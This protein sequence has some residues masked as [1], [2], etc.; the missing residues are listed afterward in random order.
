M[1][2]SNGGTLLP[3]VKAFALLPCMQTVQDRN[4]VVLLLGDRLGTILQI[5]ESPRK[6]THLFSVVQA[7]DRRPDGLQALLDVV[8]EL[9]PGTIHLRFVERMI[10]ERTALPLWPKEER[11]SLF[12][13]L[14]GMPFKDLIEL[15]R[16]VAGAGA[17]ELPAE[18]SY[19]EVFLTL[20]TMN[21]DPNGLPKAILFVEQ[22]ASGR[23]H[24]LSIELRR[25][26]DRQASRLGVIT[27]LQKTRREL[28]APPPG[29]PP[30]SPAYLV[31]MLRRVG[32][33]GDQYQLFNW[34]QLDLS[35]GWH[36][37]RGD[38]F[39]GTIDE[40]KRQVAELI[41]SVEIKWA[42]YRPDIRI[43]MVLSGELL[44]LDV[45]QWSWEVE[46]TIPAIPIGCR[47]AFAIRSLERMMSGKWHRSWHMRWS[48]L[49]GQLQTGAIEPDSH[50]RI[51]AGD[52]I[53]KLVA[54]FENNPSVVSLMLSKPPE[55]VEDG[56]PEVRV[57]LRA[58]L[59]VIVWS[60]E[61]CDSEEFL[62]AV[63]QLLHGDG[64]GDVLHRVKQ[65]RTTAY[66]SHAGHVGHSLALMWDDPE[67]LVVPADLGP[68]RDPR[69]A[70]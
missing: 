43:E 20:E 19:R 42:R 6:L 32:L 46:S 59:P 60:R 66:Q 44:N 7:C 38:D 8:R 12:A 5:E 69:E 58:G 25:W 39:T 2:S 34:S 36:P 29:P 33:T 11:D 4:F 56:G 24:E 65:I 48:V 28:K 37:E 17:P 49:A 70:A 30:N 54:D 45:D 53:R 52:S 67:R 16:Q 47:Y 9:D 57:G 22:L 62:T 23:R 27:E 10:A 40:V 14:S 1:T 68:P 61:N 35:E 15:Y 51:E 13:L 26:S 3:L 31:F 55:A 41:E 21:A 18:S 64:S 50:H 63:R